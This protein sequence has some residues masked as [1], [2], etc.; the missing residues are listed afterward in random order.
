[1]IPGRFSFLPW[2][3]ASLMKCWRIRSRWCG[4]GRLGAA[5][6]LRAGA[7]QRCA[8]LAMVAHRRWRCGP[9]RRIDA[10]VFHFAKGEEIAATP[11]DTQVERGT[12]L[13]ISARFGGAPPGEATLV[14]DLGTN[15]ESQVAMSRRLADPVFGASL[16]EAFPEGG[17]SPISSIANIGGRKHAITKSPSLNSR[18]WRTRTPSC[19]IRLTPV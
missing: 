11:G 6:G 15:K 9:A 19:S 17:K 4:G 3:C 7:L 10:S 2:C 18:P 8:F 12:A 1:M 14:L 13:V 5:S 16:P